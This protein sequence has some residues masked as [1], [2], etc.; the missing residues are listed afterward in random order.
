MFAKPATDHLGQTFPSKDAMC[1]H[2]GLRTSSF[3]S[4]I[5]N[6]WDLK[7]ALTKPIGLRQ[8]FNNYTDHEGNTFQSLSAMADYWGIPSSTL[9]R[10]IVTAKMPIKK[11]L[12]M[13]HEDARC[14]AFK[15]KD[16]LENEFPS[17]MKMC[18]HYGIDKQV[19]FGRLKMGWSLEKALTTP[20]DFQPKNSKAVTDHTGENFKS[21]SAMC[22]KWDIPRSTYNIRI[23]K[24]WTIKDA[25]TT[26]CEKLSIK[27]QEW[28]DHKGITYPSLNAMCS[29]Y[30]ITHHTFSTRIS[31]LGWS[32]EKALKTPNIINSQKC[33]DY[34]G[35]TFP[36][37]LDMAHY[38]GI[39]ETAFQGK[40]VIDKEYVQK[41]IISY[42]KSNRKVLNIKVIKV[43]QFPYF[44]VS[45][46]NHEYVFHIDKIME[47]YHNDDF[48]PI[49]K[50]KIKDKHLTIK[51]CISF[52]YYNVTFD[53]QE[54]IWDYWK[55]I[56][57]R[58]DTN[59]GLSSK[60]GDIIGK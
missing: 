59:F 23:K 15:C 16:H 11:A 17:Q 25:L 35:H 18:E 60:R 38:Y 55:I 39:P 49:P 51:S 30:G 42:W 6:G 10:R 43:I 41:M 3:D 33:T 47:L 45:C 54:M 1:K 34:F 12:T 31:K 46:D 36:S 56:E 21:I 14:E 9:Q 48:Y 5:R 50:S 37:K 28:T 57:Y 24:G 22:K 19:Y 53:G 44:M 20:L 2:Y 8:N 27:K 26:P 40:K 4:R 52:P 29:A 58:R 7:A 32:V 13:T